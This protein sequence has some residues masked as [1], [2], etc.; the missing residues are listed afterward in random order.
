MSDTVLAITTKEDPSASLFSS[1]VDIGYVSDALAM[2]PQGACD[3]AMPSQ[4]RYLAGF[5][6]CVS[7]R[8]EGIDCDSNRY[9]KL[10]DV[11]DVSA[12]I[13]TACP[14]GIDVFFVKV[15]SC[16]AAVHF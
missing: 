6:L 4:R 13:F 15:A 12:H 9:T 8:N 16:N 11:P 10:T 3:G 5:V 14:N 1:G 2:R 7:I